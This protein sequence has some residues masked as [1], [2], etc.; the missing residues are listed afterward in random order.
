MAARQR[1]VIL[2]AGMASLAAAWELTR[3]P[4]WAQKYEITVYQM[5]WRLGGKGASGRGQ[6]GRIEEHGLHIWLGFYE[7]AFR[8]I[9]EAYDQLGRP[10]GSPLATFE[11]AFAKQQIWVVEEFFEGAWKPW[12]L[13]FPVNDDTPGDGGELPSLWAYVSMAIDE[14][15]RLFAGPPQDPASPGSA[16]RW[17]ERL[18]NAAEDGEKAIELA[19]GPLL[20]QGAVALKKAIAPGGS[21]TSGHD[22]LAR[23]LVQFAQWTSRRVAADETDDT[24]RRLFILA[25]LAACAI[26]GVLRDGVLFAAGGLE[27]IDDMDLR[28]WL[29]K[30]GASDAAI[31]SAA[32]KS[33]YDLAF[34]Y[35]DGDKNQPSFAAGTALRCIVRIYFTY[36]GAMFWKMQAGM[37]D[38]IFTPLYLILKQRGVRFEFFRRVDAL[39]LSADKTAVESIEIGV[40]AVAKGGEYDPL[41]DVRG[42]ASWP[43]QPIY[44]RLE[45][46][47]ELLASGQN[48]ESFWC[49]GP[50]AGSAVLKAG[51]DFDVVALGISIASLPFIC[52]EIIAAK[53]PWKAMV[54]NVATVRTIAMQ[55]WLKPSLSQLGWPTASPVMD[56]YAE[57]LDTWADMSH[58][59]A[60]EAWSD[61][62]PSTI[63]YFCG[64]DTGDIPP[65]SESDAPAKALAKLRSDCIAWIKA[66]L[67]ALW[68]AVNDPSG[69]IDWSLLAAP[70]GVGGEERFD[71]QFIRTNMD[72]TER[73]VLAVPGSSKHRL[74]PGDSGL[75]N[76]YLTGDWV[77]NGLNA[78]CIEAAVMAGMLC[79]NAISGRPALKD[80]IGY[81]SP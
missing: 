49:T 73:Y 26:A 34:A 16:Q 66:N 44:D 6:N 61:P 51:Q 22:P 19:L 7:N 72:P 4:E 74:K 32:L 53:G 13:N 25:E 77:D 10:A 45:R 21:D 3:D 52:A 36:K 64:T 27:A 5:G 59:I 54:E 43:D 28:A 46:G 78:G 33:L 75:S 8:L 12:P 55:L 30:H 39:R 9:R 63:A 80:I 79:A 17:W 67:P 41:V 58:L 20:L 14:L 29:K 57:P 47:D 50:D 18:A 62:E 42:L 71:S 65:R 76:L 23:L 81:G 56:G 69:A 11:D 31:D 37:G 38:T 48:L 40:Q 24:A 2:G 68:P 35:R 60:R 70:P 1:I 15:H